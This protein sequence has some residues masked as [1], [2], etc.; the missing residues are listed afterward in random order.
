MI[1]LYIQRAEGA[2]RVYASV[3]HTKNNCDGNKKHGRRRRLLQLSHLT[4]LCL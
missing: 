1:A 3:L 4:F 2:K